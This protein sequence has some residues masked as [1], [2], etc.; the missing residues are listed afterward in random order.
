MV[1]ASDLIGATIYARMAKKP[2]QKNDDQSAQNNRESRHDRR[3][4]DLRKSI[5]LV[6]CRFC[7]RISSSG[8]LA[9]NRSEKW[10]AAR[11]EYILA[12]FDLRVR[13]GNA[14]QIR[15]GFSA[16]KNF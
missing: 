10:L 7:G 13:G 1:S 11:N 9:R 16:L 15:C 5:A 6:I 3:F 12:A 4:R 2:A 8:N 14:C